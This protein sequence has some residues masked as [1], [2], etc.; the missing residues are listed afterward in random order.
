MMQAPTLDHLRM[1]M[2]LLME[3]HLFD[4]GLI[5][6]VLDVIE[7][8][9][10]SVH[11]DECIFPRGCGASVS[12]EP[13]KSRVVLR[14]T[15]N[16]LDTL[17][18]IETKIQ[19]L[20]TAIQKA[21]ASMKR[22][23][24]NGDRLV[25]VATVETP[26]QLKRVLLLG[27]GRV[28][29]SFVEY[30]SRS[31]DVRVV[32]AGDK[33]DEVRAVASK[34]SNGQHV[35]LNA[36]TDQRMLSELIEDADLVCSLLPAPMH[37]LIAQ[38]CI[39]HRKH[40]VTASYESD[41][42]RELNQRAID[43]NV[44]ILNEV[45]LDPGLDHMSAMK[46][47]D[48]IKSRGGTVTRFS[49]VCG[50]LPAPEASN[51]PLRYKFSWSPLGVIRAS[52]NSALYRLDGKIVR[53]PGRDLL[54]SAE[55][56]DEA[57]PELQLECLP[58]RDSIRYE[59]VYGIENAGTIFRGTLRYSGFSRLLN[60]FKNMGL[61]EPTSIEQKNWPDIIDMLRRQSGGFESLQAFLDVCSNGDTDTSRNAMQTLEWLGLLDART[62][63]SINQS[64]VL[65]AFCSVLEDHLRYSPG[66]RDMVAMHHRIDA[67][68]DDGET[69]EHHFSQLQVFGCSKGSAM[70]KTVGYPAAASAEL[71]LEGALTE[72][73]GLLLP[74]V[75]K[76]YEPVLE[77]MEEIDITFSE[78]VSYHYPTKDHAEKA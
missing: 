10:G 53:V 61:L 52:Q 8:R 49:S 37:P 72:E 1:S 54:R 45:G 60:V 19:T 6:H 51:N 64:T 57:W 68:F 4:S 18:S 9:E 27:A 39:F 42:M 25:G 12:S 73:R 21:D 59:S 75:R 70:A 28:A 35:I 11:F 30:L 48:D 66:E 16:D 67:T 20:V 31:G 36:T 34:A 24:K 5:N 13:V 55:P 50:G 74:I 69:E 71:I 40:L 44:I 56:F 33:E 22:L 2:V 47:I 14:V 32:V 63:P 23:D 3:G 38:E 65:D 17:A 78:G 43:A 7:Q 29:T 62:C 76:V 58:N 46:I 26:K 77:K 41:E 15:A